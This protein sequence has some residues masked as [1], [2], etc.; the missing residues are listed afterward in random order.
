V[1]TPGVSIVIPTLNSAKY[2]DECLSAID[3]QDFPREHVEVIVADAGSTDATLAIA[4]RHGVDQVLE[5][6]RRTG[7][8][9]KAVGIRAA[10]RELVCMID[11]DNVIVGRDWLARMLE[12][13]SDPE[14]ISAEALRWEYRR[15]DHFINRY[16]ALTGINDPLA[17]FVGNYDR[18]SELT[19]R[20]T[21]Y[22]HESEDRDGWLKVTLDPAFVPTM[23]ANGYIVRRSAFDVVGVED[24]FFDIDF[25]YDLVQA[26][27]RTVARV[28][29]PIRH[30]FC[31]SVTRFYRKTRRRT[32]D[33]FFYA[34]E[35]RRSYPWTSRQRAGVVR[36]VAAS[37]FTVPLLAQVWR[38]LRRHRDPAWLFHVPACWITLAVYAAG[39]VRGRLAPRALDR[40]GW[41]Q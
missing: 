20:W 32:D 23:G 38:G 37:V 25:V 39:T 16:Q 8:A 35:G 30:Y 40:T 6:P 22:P 19:G 21:D 12:P 11:S 14:V 10:R 27:R 18:F 24:Y 4:H 41:A 9:G 31:D 2:L 7:E 34:S 3:A 17:L 33:Y 13:F 36:F 1:S 15:E 5:N 26:G 29:V 28:D